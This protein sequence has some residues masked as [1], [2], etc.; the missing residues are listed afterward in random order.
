MVELSLKTPK[1]KLIKAFAIVI[2]IVVIIFGSIFGFASFVN[3][4][5]SKA[6]ATWKM[7]PPEVTASKASAETWYPSVNFTRR[8]GVCAFVRQLLQHLIGFIVTAKLHHGFN[9][10]RLAL[11]ALLPILFEFR[12]SRGHHLRGNL[13]SGDRD[14]AFNH[15]GAEDFAVYEKHHE[16]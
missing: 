10:A 3:D 14:N 6:M 2:A 4:K 12:V 9:N 1:K 11:R 13:T 16:N 8:A 7:Q 15:R 5:K